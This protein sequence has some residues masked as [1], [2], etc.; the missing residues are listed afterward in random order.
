M[1]LETHCDQDTNAINLIA[2]EL[3]DGTL[4][5]KV[6][7]DDHLESDDFSKAENSKNI[8]LRNLDN[9]VLMLTKEDTAVFEHM[10][11][12]EIEGNAP[13]TKFIIQ[14]YK[15]SNPRGLAV[16]IL[17]RDKK[18]IY[19]LSCQGKELQ[20]QAGTSPHLINSDASDVIFY[21][22]SVKG[23]KKMQFESSLYQKYFLACEKEE[24][25]Y[26]KLILKKVCQE[27]DN[28]TLFT[29]NYC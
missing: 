21:Q 28:V 18:Q 3:R 14:T 9:Q 13:Q 23:H 1:A 20:F 16:A 11:Q 7:D 26:Y 12:K 22:K 19:T 29:V 4:Y 24:S 2:M 8:I 15:E 5:F 10:T 17:V 6:E 27:E 25:G